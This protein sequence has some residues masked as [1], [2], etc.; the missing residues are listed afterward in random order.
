[1]NHNKHFPRSSNKVIA[2][3]AHVIHAVSAC[4]QP[5]AVFS[6]TNVAMFL[7][8]R[9]RIIL[10]NNRVNMELTTLLEEVEENLRVTL[11]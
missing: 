7:L 10:M 9:M 1:M 3:Q 4:L 8:C 11:T 2:T 5:A 6:S